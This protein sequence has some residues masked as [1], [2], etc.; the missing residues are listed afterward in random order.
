MSV[1]SNFSPPSAYEMLR[2]QYASR[3]PTS[4]EELAGPTAGTVDLPLHVVWSGRRSYGLSQPRSRMSLYRTVLAEGQNQ[5]LIDYLDRSLL[6]AQ[7]PI[8]RTLI[9]RPLRDAWESRFP[10]LPTDKAITAA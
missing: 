1:P 6:I 7:W 5:D 10:E 4:L 3:L 2:E 8:L 9:S